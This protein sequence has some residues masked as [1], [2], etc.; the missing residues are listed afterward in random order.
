MKKEFE[1]KMIRPQEDKGKIEEVV[2]TES[3]GDTYCFPEYSISVKAHSV[4]E[5]CEKLKELLKIKNK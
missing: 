3:E 5:A 4:G 2:V 1:D